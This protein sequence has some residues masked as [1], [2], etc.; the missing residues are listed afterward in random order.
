MAWR[1]PRPNTTARGL[2]WHHQLERRRLLPLAYG[3]LCPFHQDDPRCPG[4]MERGQ[5]LELDHSV[6]RALGG[7]AAPRRMAH[8]G[9]NRRAGA[10]L[11]NQMSRAAGRAG[12]PSRRW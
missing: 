6:P 12:R 5:A 10:R 3:T 1:G 4:L 8:A 7:H 9:C 11:G 2:G